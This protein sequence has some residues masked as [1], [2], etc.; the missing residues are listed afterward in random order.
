MKKNLRIRNEIEKNNFKY[1]EIAERL[2]LSDGNFSRLLRRELTEE[3]QKEIL[4]II[5]KL[6]EKQ[7][8]GTL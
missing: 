6:K 1:W 4:K 3:K 5:K 2:N 8:N 7:K